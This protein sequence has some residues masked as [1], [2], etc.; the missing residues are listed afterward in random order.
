[1]R[2]RICVCVRSHCVALL[3]SRGVDHSNGWTAALRRCETCG[4]HS[5][6]A[7]PD[8]LITLCGTHVEK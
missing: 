2:M 7:S 4:S 5:H 3:R 6:L 1:M 8:A